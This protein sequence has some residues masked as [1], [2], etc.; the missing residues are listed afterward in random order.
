[1]NK[2]VFLSNELQSP[3]VQR[4][5]RLP[6]QFIS[7]AYVEGKMYRHFRN[8]STFIL[9]LE[10][11]RRW[12][13]LNI[14]G[15][16]FHIDDFDFYIRILDAYHACSL[17]TLL[18]NHTKDTHHRHYTNAIPIYFDSLDDMGRLKY[19]EKEKILSHVYIGNPN[20]DKIKRR[21]NQKSV[22]YR[23]IEGV[24]KKHFQE[25]YKEVKV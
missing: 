2:L 7:F 1:M 11:S 18:T 12:G 4:E 16:L 22:S 8:E 19:R 13:N 20:H 23:V 17:S 25:L 15:A 10:T 21:V 24:H 9:P 5:L 6:L 3:L 14:Y